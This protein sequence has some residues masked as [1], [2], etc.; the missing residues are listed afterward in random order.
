MRTIKTYRKVGAFYIACE[1]DFSTSIRAGLPN[2]A[3]DYATI[4]PSGRWEVGSE[5]NFRVG[6][7]SFGKPEISTPVTIEPKPDLRFLGGTR[8]PRV[9]YK[10]QSA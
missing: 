1:E 6:D 4:R 3:S 9:K 2:V 5:D 8:L 7:R 10:R